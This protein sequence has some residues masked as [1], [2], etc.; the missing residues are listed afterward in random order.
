[1][2]ARKKEL[3]ALAKSS[4]RILDKIEGYSLM[5]PEATFYVVESELEAAQLLLAMAAMIRLTAKDVTSK[6]DRAQ[7]L[8]VA[9]EYR[10]AV[11]D[12]QA[13]N[14]FRDMTEADQ[15]ELYGLKLVA[16]RVHDP[17]DAPPQI[18]TH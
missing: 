7:Y 12:G 15:L 6:L 8:K 1:M 18:I 4:G 10:K 14:K 16:M 9:R 2:T 13:L 11:I 5:N 3:S 17:A